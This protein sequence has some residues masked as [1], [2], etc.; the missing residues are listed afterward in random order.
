M[1]S[2]AVR[3]VGVFV[4]L[5]LVSCFGDSTG[6][7][8]R[9]RAGVAFQPVFDRQA[10]LLVDFTRVRITLVRPATEGLAALDTTVDFPSDQDSLRLSLSVPLSPGATSESFDL[11][12]AM[13]DATGAVVFV[14]GPTRVTVTAGVFGGRAPDVP[15][16]YVGTGSNATGVRFRAPV[17]TTAYFGETVVFV[18]EAYDAEGVAIAGT[19]IVYAVD[20]A[21]AARAEVPDPA[22]GRVVAK[23][24]RGQAAVVARLL[25]EQTPARTSLTVQPRPSAI[26]V[27]GGNAQ[28][29]PVG[30][31]LLQPITVRVTAADGL[32]VQGVAVTFAVTTGGGSLSTTLGTTD[33]SG[34]AS[35]VWTL[36]NAAGS[37]TVT[38]TAGTLSTSPISATATAGVAVQLVFAVQPS[39]ANANVVVAPPVQVAARDGFGNVVT[40]YTGTVSLG[41]GVNPG[42][43]SLGGTT[44]VAAVA[45]VAA[46]GTLTVSNGGNGY[47]LVAT[48]TGL[49]LATSSLFNVL[50]GAPTKLG[51]VTQPTT[52]VAGSQIAPA[53]RVAVQDV[54][55]TTVPSATNLVTLAITGG[56]GAAGAVLGGTLTQ[57]AVNGVATFSNL[58]LDK[59]GAGYTLTA[60]ATG[61]SSAP[62]SAFSITAGAAASLALVSGDNQSAAPSAPL[63]L[64][65]VVKVADAFGNGVSGR[66]VAFAVATGGGSVGTPSATTD[67]T[68]SASTAWTLGATGGAQSITATSSGLTGSP[69]TIGATAVAV[70]SVT[71]SPNTTSVMVGQVQPFTATTR[72]AAGSVLTGRVITWAS[73]DNTIATVDGTGLA[74]ALRAGRAVITAT[75]EGVSGAATLTATA[76]PVSTAQSY[77]VVIPA[78]VASGGFSTIYLYSVDSVGNLVTSGGHIVAF[79]L[80]TNGT[81]TGTIGPV[82]DAGSGI[83]FATFTGGSPGTPVTVGATIDGVGVT[84]LL[85]TI[86]VVVFS[87]AAVPLAAGARHVCWIPEFG[88]TL[89]WGA[90][91]SGQ[92]GDGSTTG[93]ANPVPVATQQIFV[94]VTAG[95]DHTC[96]LTGDGTAYCWGANTFGQLGTGTTPP[97]LTPAAVTGG[98]KFS[99]ILAGNNFTCGIDVSGT[100]YCWGNNGGKLGDGNPT[101]NASAPRA[102]FGTLTFTRLGLWGDNHA[103]GIAVGGAAY[104]WGYNAD[105][106]LGD[107]TT[108]NRNVPTLVAAGGRP[109]SSVTGA[110]FH[111][112]ALAAGGAAYCWG[113]NNVSQLGYGTP[114]TDNLVPDAVLG[115]SPVQGPYSFTS[116]TAGANHTCGLLADLSAACW[117]Y[118]AEGELAE[119]A[120]GDGTKVTRLRPAPA[121]AGVQ[122]SI[123]AAGDR[124]TCGLVVGASVLCWGLRIGP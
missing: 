38:A 32:G 3:T 52:A 108:S 87:V 50:G 17:P 46:F 118:N 63:L 88:L 117:G 44:S 91:A 69:L 70:S 114:P 105:G 57:A 51:F 43:A 96:A 73:S 37:Q 90:N 56:T 67:A 68:G 83:Y 77:V 19:P 58:T 49:T 29:G 123:L 27:T 59:A 45:G 20:P 81:S 26:A 36:G 99:Q 110:T 39:N 31:A 115:P 9:R 124:F 113:D 101:S 18:A 2:F 13:L 16:T 7:G 109:F 66:S 82:T 6:P 71:V 34:Y 103:C 11:M 25:T 15:M 14:G 1:R 100:A 122:F 60:G 107:G 120:L 80:G 85:P 10:L 12:L 33:S 53:I 62:S 94:A 30:G 116:L 92:L 86:Q 93:S 21:D 76:V 112:C 79:S 97:S 78:V 23:S 61:L 98:L 95:G 8:E 75:S 22:V 106:E 41:F 121:K 48:A 89:C 54:N 64:P 72:D 65:I 55:G 119:G 42:G 35:V 74:T 84:S 102:V 47:T 5:F 40:T 104:C 111:T 4:A 24:V 28:T